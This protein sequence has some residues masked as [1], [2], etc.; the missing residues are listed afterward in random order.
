[1]PGTIH[2]TYIED[3]PD[4]INFMKMALEGNNVKYEMKTL[5]RGD[6]A[7]EWSRQVKKAPDLIIM[8][9]N[10]PKVHG[11]ELICI[12][13]NTPVLRDVPLLVLTTSSLQEDIDFCR[14]NGANRY[15]TKPS[16]IDGFTSLASVIV[17]MATGQRKAAVN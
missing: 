12:L 8:D 5:M 15:M 14:T 13:K 3:D 17:G 6:L 10:L 2:I 4:D 16:D 7:L 9:L 11:R 1:M